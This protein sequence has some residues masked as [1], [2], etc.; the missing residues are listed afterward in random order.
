MVFGMPKVSVDIEIE[1]WLLIQLSLEA[2]RQN[3]TLNQL[4]VNILT[5]AVKKYGENENCQSN[6]NNFTT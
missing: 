5:E 4:I 3:I 1:D 6:E 2:H